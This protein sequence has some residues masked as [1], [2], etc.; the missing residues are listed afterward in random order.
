[1]KIFKSLKLY[2]SKKLLLNFIYWREKEIHP[3]DA[4]K[5]IDKYLTEK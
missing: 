1:M 5:I 4:N 3:A 2:F